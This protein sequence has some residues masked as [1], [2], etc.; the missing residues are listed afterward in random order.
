M[1]AVL[2]IGENMASVIWLSIHEQRPLI[3]YPEVLLDIRNPNG[4]YIRPIIAKGNIIE[5][6]EAKE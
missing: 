4:H 2:E 5:G 3:Q 1:V 6:I